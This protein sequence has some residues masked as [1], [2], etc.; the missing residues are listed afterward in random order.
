MLISQSEVDTPKRIGPETTGGQCNSSRDPFSPHH[1]SEPVTDKDAQKSERQTIYTF[2]HFNEIKIDIKALIS[3]QRPCAPANRP[4]TGPSLRRSKQTPHPSRRAPPRRPHPPTGNDGR[5]RTAQHHGP[6][7]PADPGDR[8]HGNVL[9]PRVAG[10]DGDA[11]GG[12]ELPELP[13]QAAGRGADRDAEAD[14]RARLRPP[15]VPRRDGRGGQ[16]QGEGEAAAA[17][18]ELRGRQRRGG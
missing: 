17:E 18:T 16:G 12:A 8:D 4:F 11:G 7:L 13:G 9:L 1:A 2:Y 6:L 5:R 15:D 10:H 14:A 3:H